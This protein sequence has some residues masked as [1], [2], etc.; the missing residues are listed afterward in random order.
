MAVTLFPQLL[1]VEEK[2]CGPLTNNGSGLQD[3]GPGEGG[4]FH[5]TDLARVS[6]VQQLLRRSYSHHV[7][8]VGMVSQW[9]IASCL[10]VWLRLVQG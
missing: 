1:N 10:L 4:C 2:V 9:F 6:H 7:G 8:R 5:Q 3:G